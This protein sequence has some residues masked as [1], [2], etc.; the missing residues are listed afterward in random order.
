[1]ADDTPLMIEMQKGHDSSEGDK[2]KDPLNPPKTMEE[3]EDTASLIRQLLSALE[4]HRKQ[5][6]HSKGE[7]IPHLLHLN[8]EQSVSST[9]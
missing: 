1:M 9:L 2:P 4:K 7:E 8:C 5:G 3:K 6:E